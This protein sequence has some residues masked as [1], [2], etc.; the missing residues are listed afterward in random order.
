MTSDDTVI[1]DLPCK[2]CAY[3]LRGLSMS[4]ICPECTEPVRNSFS[5]ATSHLA[6]VLDED[7]VNFAHRLY[8]EKIANSMGYS[9]DAVLF[10]IDVYSQTK[11]VDPAKDVTPADIC[12]ALRT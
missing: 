7:P 8:H 6:K 9:V 2:T 5:S 11:R 1:H 12:A 4:G 3:N 10:V